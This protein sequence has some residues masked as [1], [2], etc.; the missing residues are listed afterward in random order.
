MATTTAVGVYPHISMLDENGKMR[1]MPGWR[2]VDRHNEIIGRNMPYA[3][4]MTTVFLDPEDTSLLRG[5]RNQNSKQVMLSINELPSQ[6]EPEPLPIQSAADIQQR[7]RATGEIYSRK[8]FRPYPFY[9]VDGF[10]DTVEGET[11][12]DSKDG[13]DQGYPLVIFYPLF[14]VEKVKS[15]ERIKRSQPS[16]AAT[17][18]RKIDN[19]DYGP[20]TM[21]NAQ[22]DMWHAQHP[23]EKLVRTSD[24]RWHHPDFYE[25][26]Y[27]TS[28]GTQYTEA[29]IRRREDL[30]LFEHQGAEYIYKLSRHCQDVQLYEAHMAKK[31]RRYYHEVAMTD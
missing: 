22:A 12:K 4:K 2:K 10:N 17:T 26:Q 1:M 21:G 27:Q 3:C 16:D 28:L 15:T 11:R 25:I 7:T 18:Q 19:W 13:Q 8:E 20:W 31:I 9:D 23:T 5:E 24:G 6:S 30:G 29:T 14:K